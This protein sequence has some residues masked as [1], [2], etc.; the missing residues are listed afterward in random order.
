M[1]N[2]LN[3]EAVYTKSVRAG[4]RDY[5]FDIKSTSNGD[6]YIVLTE[7]T[8]KP[9]GDRFVLEKHKIFLYKEDINKFSKAFRGTIDHFK[10]ELMVNY[11]FS[12]PEND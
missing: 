5:H 8:K 12:K 4:R 11:D 10:N 9:D 7:C 2:K 6:Y 3:N 1:Y